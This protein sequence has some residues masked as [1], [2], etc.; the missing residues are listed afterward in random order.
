MLVPRF[1]AVAPLLRLWG[2]L[3]A[4]TLMCT[5]L[6]TIAA[7]SQL[8]VVADNLRPC[9]HWL[10]APAA[11]SPSS[12]SLCNGLILTRFCDGEYKASMHSPSSEI[13]P[14]DSRPTTAFPACFHALHI[15]SVCWVLGPANGGR[16]L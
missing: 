12:I 10:D 16:V 5:L 14:S 11:I 3:A 8:V 9:A 15:R 1:A 13:Q 7:I 4:G 6:L 2:E